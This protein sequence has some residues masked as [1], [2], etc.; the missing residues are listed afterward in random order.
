MTWGGGGSDG[1][2]STEVSDMGGGGRGLMGRNSTEVSDMGGGGGRERNK[3][4]QAGR[5]G[6]LCEEDEAG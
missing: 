1:R 5:R 3:D 6:G 4:F 2:N